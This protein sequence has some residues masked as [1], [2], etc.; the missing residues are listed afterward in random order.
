M[1]RLNKRLVHS[2]N[3]LWGMLNSSTVKTEA[4]FLLQTQILSLLPPAKLCMK[5]YS[6]H[7]FSEDCGINHLEGLKISSLHSS[8]TF[9]RSSSCTNSLISLIRLG[10]P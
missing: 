3:S 9:K 7:N 4:I 1:F 8:L 6:E 10:F 5:H 2:P